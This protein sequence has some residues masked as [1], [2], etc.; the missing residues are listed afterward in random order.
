MTVVPTVLP[1]RRRDMLL[2]DHILRTYAVPS[3]LLPSQ[4]RGY[5]GHTCVRRFLSSAFELFS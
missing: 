5:R 1:L 2:I 4:I 3:N